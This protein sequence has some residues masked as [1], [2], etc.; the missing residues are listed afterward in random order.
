M[1]KKDF[2]RIVIA[3]IIGYLAWGHGMYV[4]GIAAMLPVILFAGRPS[5]W[6]VGLSAVAYYG[7]AA[8]GAILGAATFFPTAGGLLTGITLWAASSL[9]LGASWS[10]IG[11]SAAGDRRSLSWRLLSIYIV[12]ALPPVGL[13]AWASPLTS[14]GV[15]FPGAGLFGVIALVIAQFVSVLTMSS[16]ARNPHR[17]ILVGLAVCSA[18][19]ITTY[20]P[21]PTPQGWIGINTRYLPSPGL[22]LR[23]V[24]H[25]YRLAHLALADARKGYT[26]IV[27]PELSAGRW[28]LGTEIL[29]RSTIAK[30]PVGTTVYIGAEIPRGPRDYF[31]ALIPITNTRNGVHLATPLP[32]RIPIPFGEWRPWP[33]AHSA[34]ADFFGSGIEKNGKVGYLICYEDLLTLPY[35]NFLFNTPRILITA[36]SDWFSP[37]AAQSQ[38][39]AASAWAQ[40]MRVP[41]IHAVNH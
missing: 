22:S 12:Q 19:L 24:A 3:A 14:A 6:I 32:A 1:T 25:D 20:T 37:E 41:L 23:A 28:L 40:L 16:G 7:A 9:I 31:D 27:L 4:I 13:I 2:A 15:I 18:T 35:V 8:R 36:N 29:W 39:E 30:M 17:A 26:H 5:R 33:D 34:I 21:P 11:P 10:L 38:I